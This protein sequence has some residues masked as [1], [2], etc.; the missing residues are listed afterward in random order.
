[1]SSVPWSKAAF[2]LANGYHL[3]DNLGPQHSTDYPDCL[4]ATYLHHRTCARLRLSH[5][6]IFP[7]RTFSM[8]RAASSCMSGRTC[9]YVSSLHLPIQT[10]DINCSKVCELKESTQVVG[11]S[12]LQLK[13]LSQT[14]AFSIPQ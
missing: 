2:D 11:R 13:R 1:M 8:R 7:K 3:L 12:S 14:A 10:W 5:A 6:L 4:G 9:E